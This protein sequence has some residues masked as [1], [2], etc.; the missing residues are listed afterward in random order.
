MK[1]KFTCKAQGFQDML[2]GTVVRDKVDTDKAAKWDIANAC[3]KLMIAK[4]VTAN[5][6]VYIAKCKMENEMWLSI[7]KKFAKDANLSP[8]YVIAALFSQTWNGEADTLEPF[9]KSTQEQI[10][11]L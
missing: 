10:V 6:Y 8:V 5:D 1:L 7:K 11:D 2:F 4:C 9:L 3:M